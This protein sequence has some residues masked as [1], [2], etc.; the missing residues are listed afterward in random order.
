MISNLLSIITEKLKRRRKFDLSPNPSLPP[1]E[2]NAQYQ[3]LEI[4]DQF[5]HYAYYIDTLPI[6][7]DAYIDLSEKWSIA[8]NKTLDFTVY[9][10]YKGHFEAYYY[11]KS[12][13]LS[14]T[15][16]LSIQEQELQGNLLKIIDEF[17]SIA[18]WI[19]NLL[20]K[21]LNK[22]SDLWSSSLVCAMNIC[23]ANHYILYYNISS[24]GENIS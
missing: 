12:I 20:G 16:L 10:L 2:R 9:N 7:K 8:I 6:N 15:P 18:F 5:S 13:D 24:T 19:N 17:A 4:I 21:D 11:I 14:P 23:I 3:L 1:L 22:Y